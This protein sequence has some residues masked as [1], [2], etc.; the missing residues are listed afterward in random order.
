M[1]QKQKSSLDADL[2]PHVP[3]KQYADV[4]L[5]AEVYRAGRTK[6]ARRRH[7]PITCLCLHFGQPDFFLRLH[8]CSPFPLEDSFRSLVRLCF[9]HL[10]NCLVPS[11]CSTLLDLLFALGPFS[12]FFCHIPH[13]VLVFSTLLVSS[14]FFLA[15]PTPSLF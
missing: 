14:H 10:Y 2:K 3:H 12:V 13:I 11:L 1:V 4:E 6:R 5:A 7:V 15:L 8:R 9:D